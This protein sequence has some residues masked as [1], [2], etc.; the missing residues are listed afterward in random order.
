MKHLVAYIFIAFA[1]YLSYEDKITIE[2]QFII[3][4][5]CLIWIEIREILH[6]IHKHS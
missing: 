6:K 1:F 5:L 2:S 4:V 3:T